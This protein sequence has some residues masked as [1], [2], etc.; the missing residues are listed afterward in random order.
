MLGTASRTAVV[1]N[2]A[3][4]LVKREGE[5]ATVTKAALPGSIMRATHQLPGVIT[6]VMSGVPSPAAN[7]PRATALGRR[8][9]VP[10]SSGEGGEKEGEKPASSP[11]TFA[12]QAPVPAS[13]PVLMERSKVRRD[14]VPESVEGSQPATV[15][16]ASLSGVTS[17]TQ[18][19]LKNVVAKAAAGKQNGGQPAAINMPMLSSVLSVPLETSP[20]ASPG[21]SRFG[22]RV[23][24]LPV[25]TSSVV[26]SP[27]VSGLGATAGSSV[28]PSAA[29]SQPA[30]HVQQSGP[31]QPTRPLLVLR[32]SS[33]DPTSGDRRP[34][35]S[36]ELRH[37]TTDALL[38]LQRSSTNSVNPANRGLASPSVFSQHVHN[39]LS[40]MSSPME[41]ERTPPV[42]NHVSRES[43][44]QQYSGGVDGDPDQP[45]D[46]SLKSKR[47]SPLSDSKTK[48]QADQGAVSNRDLPSTM[49]NIPDLTLSQPMSSYS[50][51]KRKSGEA[52]H[53][54]PKPK[55]RSRAK[56]A[57]TASSPG[58]KTDQG[59]GQ[60][61]EAT[62][63]SPSG[64]GQRTSAGLASRSEGRTISVSEGGLGRT[65]SVNE[66]GLVSSGGDASVKSAEITRAVVQEGRH[67][68]S[69][70]LRRTLG[71]P[72]KTALS[73][74]PALHAGG[75]SFLKRELV[76]V[77]T[78]PNI[79][80]K[81]VPPGLTQVLSTSFD[82]SD[83][84]DVSDGD[85][86]GASDRSG[87]SS[88]TSSK[89][90]ISVPQQ[91]VSDTHASRHTTAWKSVSHRA[92]TCT[93]V[94]QYV[95]T[96]NP[97]VP[98][99]DTSVSISFSHRAQPVS[100]VVQKSTPF[101]SVSDT[102][103]SVKTPPPSTAVSRPTDGAMVVRMGDTTMADERM[104]TG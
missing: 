79:K 104:E 85:R 72:E 100:A 14:S 42:S 71:A 36:I 34:M 68:S 73:P 94:S 26:T 81:T 48:G 66:S 88:K 28:S 45:K 52:Q 22:H 25:P 6:K 86:H 3:I 35:G 49:G 46:L 61:M 19:A 17:V 77:S 92:N 103:T 37:V 60:T 65:I 53:G 89:P 101:S 15:R 16:L 54:S 87:V 32:R 67:V 2:V 4:P 21:S 84:S 29:H 30:A 80:D 58:G 69:P 93:P 76:S 96:S 57:G 10:S 39:I 38:A 43:L 11:L 18:E 12:L 20:L 40:G 91:F 33:L 102:A 62:G 74:S 56:A 83:R 50:Q 59:G 9:S 63:S 13:A 95:N 47:A 23:T 51:R 90:V 31:A 98:L 24:P 64:E 5:N 75:S 7:T 70:L 78:S 41:T 1:K 8:N 44:P 27:A 55:R 99:A 82:V 97:V